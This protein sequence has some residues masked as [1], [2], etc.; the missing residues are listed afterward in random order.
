MEAISNTQLKKK[1]NQTPHS[2]VGVRNPEVLI[3]SSDMAAVLWWKLSGFWCA[4]HGLS[5]P[6]LTSCQPGRN[7]V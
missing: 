3:F 2:S 5:A 1:E 6:Q 7:S 4:F